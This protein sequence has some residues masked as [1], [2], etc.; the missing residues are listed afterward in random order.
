[1]CL[2]ANF[3]TRIHLRRPANGPIRPLPLSKVMAVIILVNSLGEN[4]GDGFGIREQFF[5]IAGKSGI[6]LPEDGF[7]FGQG[8]RDPQSGQKNR[9]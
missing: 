1:M 4:R 3:I 9:L 2:G 6:V 7:L 5:Q 8:E